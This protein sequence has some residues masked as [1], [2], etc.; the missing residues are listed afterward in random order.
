MKFIAS[1]FVGFQITATDL[2]NVVDARPNI[3]FDPAFV[4][5]FVWKFS[6]FFSVIYCVNIFMEGNFSLA[7]QTNDK[8]LHIHTHTHPHDDTLII[9]KN[10]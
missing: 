4:F 6:L 5:T 7:M 8:A 10:I 3:R 2:P 1:V 9:C